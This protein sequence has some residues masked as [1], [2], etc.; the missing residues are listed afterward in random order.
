MAKIIP[1]RRDEILSKE[2][3]GE[4][5]FLNYLEE[6]AD[7]T[8]TSTEATEADPASVNLSNA[9]VSQIN[10]KIAEIVSESLIT[11]NALVSKLNKRIEQLENVIL[12]SQSGAT[13]K[14]IKA[15]ENDFIAPFYKTKYEKLTIK[16]AIIDNATINEKLKLPLDNDATDPTIQFGDG[17]TGIYEESDDVLAI[18]V[19]SIKRF[20]YR[21]SDFRSEATN[22]AAMKF[23]TPTATTP[24]LVPNVN[25]TDTGIGWAAANSL[26]LVAGGVEG[27]RVT[28]AGVIINAAVGITLN[29]TVTGPSGSW[30]STGMDLAS[31]DTY[32]IN[33]TVVLN[34]TTLGSG[35]TA[36][37][38]TSLGTIGSLV[39]TT[40]D[41]NNGTVE[42]IIGGTTPKAGTFTSVNTTGAYSVDGTQVVSNQ[43][44]AVSDAA[45][46]ATIDAEARVA[47]NL[48]LARVRI[49]G[50]I[51]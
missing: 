12:G 15:I 51:A 27:I 5:R 22:S 32:S 45:G 8:N 31:G 30:S 23:T 49:H 39:A 38:L 2:G 28:S 21:F 3:L 34:A 10:K 25:D 44:A 36:S 14:K 24:S 41:I 19:D 11:N 1:P 9:Q 50:L 20:T 16:L 37:S 43:G 46:G 48:L 35:V 29:G 4:L 26:S 7:Q 42:A 13:N 40:A 33:G 18:T 47:I 17:D 6:N